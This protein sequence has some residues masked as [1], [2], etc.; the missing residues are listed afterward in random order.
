MLIEQWIGVYLAIVSFYSAY[1]LLPVVL[2][3]KTLS[4]SLFAL[5]VLSIFTSSILVIFS[6]EGREWANLSAII[7]CLCALFALVRDSKPVFARFPAYF[8]LMPLISFLF[9]P[10]IMNTK[11]IENLVIATY[12]GGAITVGLLI[13]VIHQIKYRNHLLLLSGAILFLSSYIL[14]WFFKDY[15]SISIFILGVA[16][17]LISQGLVSKNNKTLNLE[18]ERRTP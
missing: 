8:S 1:I 11:V 16:I 13:I 14:F 10:V 5:S 9:Y 6:L 15:S 4:S 18:D 7:F 17:I 12:Q 3:S 2:H